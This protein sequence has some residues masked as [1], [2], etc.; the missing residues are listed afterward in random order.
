MR[1]RPSSATRADLEVLN[2]AGIKDATSVLV[3]THDDA[4]NVY[5]TLY[6]RRL[7]PDMLILSRSTLDRNATHAAPRW[8]GLRFLVRVNG[9]QR[10]FQYAPATP[11]AVCR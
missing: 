6:C 8:R 10:R 7:R 1:R 2:D 5:L 11:H 9:R 3:T 4:V